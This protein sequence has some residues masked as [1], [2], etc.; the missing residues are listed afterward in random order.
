[1]PNPSFLGEHLEYTQ[2]CS[3]I[4]L[5]KKNITVSTKYSVTSVTFFFRYWSDILYV[6]H[7]DYIFSWRYVYNFILV[8]DQ[9][10]PSSCL[11]RRFTVNKER[12][13]HWYLKPQKRHLTNH[14]IAGCCGQTPLIHRTHDCNNY[15]IK[16]LLIF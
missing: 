4:C 16:R 10:I 15:F 5:R 9:Y 13:E 2:S 14:G 3:S 7:P 1:M 6:E 12:A 8:G 11:L